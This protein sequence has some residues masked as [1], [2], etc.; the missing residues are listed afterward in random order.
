MQRYCV[1]G[2]EREEL[3]KSGIWFLIIEKSVNFT[4]ALAA[5]HLQKEVGKF[6]CSLLQEIL[7]K[8]TFMRILKSEQKE[9]LRDGVF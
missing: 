1:E 6:T 2:N 5:F 3:C 8:Y 9:S 7:Q 4:P